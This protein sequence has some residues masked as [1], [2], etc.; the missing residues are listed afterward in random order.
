[1][2]EEYAAKIINYDALEIARIREIRNHNI[3]AWRTTW[4][5]KPQLSHPSYIAEYEEMWGIT[6]D[7]APRQLK[8]PRMCLGTDQTIARKSRIYKAKILIWVDSY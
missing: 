5:Q 8:E 4:G 7:D 1:M 6:D 3:V 2:D